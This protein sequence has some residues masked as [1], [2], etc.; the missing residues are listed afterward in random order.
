MK[1]IIRLTESDLTRIVRRVIQEQSQSTFNYDAYKNSVEKQMKG[2]VGVL[3]NSEFKGLLEGEIQVYSPGA[4]YY[5]NGGAV[6]VTTPKSNVSDHL[7]KKTFYLECNSD[8]S[9]KNVIYNVRNDGSKAVFPTYFSDFSK[10]KALETMAEGTAAN[11]C[12]FIHKTYKQM[13]TPTT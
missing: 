8:G 7:M 9:A 13:N 3:N 5:P 6:F 2:Y 4:K 12:G 11:F 1:K 10:H